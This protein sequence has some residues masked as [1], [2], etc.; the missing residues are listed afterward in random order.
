[1]F[2]DPTQERK[3]GE[4]IK[5]KAK[6]VGEI[7]RKGPRK[8]GGNIDEDGNEAP[9]AGK[10]CSPWLGEGSLG[11]EEGEGGD[12]QFRRWGCLGLKRKKVSDTRKSWE[13][14]GAG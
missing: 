6:S 5:V 14:R 4:R 3:R 11:E 1:V 7:H 8:K 10:G 12:T 2:Q 9:D 13:T